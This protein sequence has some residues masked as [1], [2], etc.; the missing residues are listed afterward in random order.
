[1]NEAAK[2]NGYDDSQIQKIQ[3]REQNKKLIKQHIT[4]LPIGTEIPRFASIPFFSSN[5]HKLTR[6]FNKYNIQMVHTN[7]QKLNNRLGP[8]KNKTPK[9]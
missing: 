8:P 4:L 2:I 6:L 7:N 5:T 1:M 3:T 9:L